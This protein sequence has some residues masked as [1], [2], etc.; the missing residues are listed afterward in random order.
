MIL[1]NNELD[2][3]IICL[4]ALIIDDNVAVIIN[5]VEGVFTN[6]ITKEYDDVLEVLDNIDF[7]IRNHIEYKKINLIEYI[8]EITDDF[9]IRMYVNENV[10]I[11]KIINNL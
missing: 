7:E 4:D 8:C 6:N 11:E 9:S 3:L 5:N 2:N 1:E 10:V